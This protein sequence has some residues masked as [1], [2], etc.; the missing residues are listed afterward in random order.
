MKWLVLFHIKEREQRWEIFKVKYLKEQGADI[1]KRT[2]EGATP[3][4]I[5]AEG[6]HNDIVEYLLEI[7]ADINSKT[8]G[9]DTP[10]MWAAG[11]N[12]PATVK[13]LVERGADLKI[14]NGNRKT[15]HDFA[16]NAAVSD[17]LEGKNLFQFYSFRIFF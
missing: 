6:G 3:L 15:V 4:H 11:R 13:F 12:R 16:P 17:A 1:N 7:G 5:A 14:V 9:G 10:I 8:N 2:I